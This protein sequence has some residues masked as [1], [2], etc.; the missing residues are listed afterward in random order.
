MTIFRR[1]PS[2]DGIPGHYFCFPE[3]RACNRWERTT[4][5]HDI[6][7][8]QCLF[9]FHVVIDAC[10]TASSYGI[11]KVLAGRELQT[12]NRTR[13]WERVAKCQV[14]LYEAV[15]GKSQIATE[16]RERLERVTDSAERLR[17]LPLWSLLST[18]PVAASDL[19]L[20]KGEIEDLCGYAV[21]LPPAASVEDAV[22]YRNELFSGVH[23][24][25]QYRGELSRE[26]LEEF[27]N[28][29]LI[30]EK[31]FYAWLQMGLY[32]LRLAEATT[33]MAQYILT[34]EHLFS[35]LESGETFG[36]VE[37][38]IWTEVLIHLHRWGRVLRMYPNGT[39]VA[40]A[41]NECMALRQYGIRF[42]HQCNGNQLYCNWEPSTLS[43]RQN[44][45]L[46]SVIRLAWLGAA[47]ATW[48]RR[49][50]STTARKRDVLR[51][52]H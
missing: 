47:R 7:G 43:G 20:R 48:G 25:L 12:D 16:Q 9:N 13:F 36:W 18:E 49:P 11:E 39:S 3:L 24:A 37:R 45:Q 15:S 6:E 38:T 5:Q 22:R 27:Q 32:Y 19:V 8:M 23:G 17:R 40:D 42:K 41:L 28:T 10:K 4:K 14:N 46:D 1:L 33:N 31:T 35:V 30:D 51:A 52:S 29:G 50:A 26:V 21:P 44:D 34:Y 2:V